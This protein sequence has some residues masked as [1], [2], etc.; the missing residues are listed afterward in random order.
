MLKIYKFKHNM[1][2]VT[3]SFGTIHRYIDLLKL[4]INQARSARSLAILRDQYIYKS[5]N[6]PHRNSLHQKRVNMFTFLVNVR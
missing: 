5:I 6:L 3:L 4:Y 1:K 2:N